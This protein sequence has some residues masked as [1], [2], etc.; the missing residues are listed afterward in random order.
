M[1][2]E[3]KS[4][5]FK[6]ASKILF[7][8]KQTKNYLSL[9]NK[10]FSSNQLLQNQFWFLPI[11]FKKLVRLALKCL[12][13]G[14]FTV[15]E[16]ED[17]TYSIWKELTRF[18]TLSDIIFTVMLVTIPPYIY[19]EIISTMSFRS[20]F[21]SKPVHCQYSWWCL[22]GRTLI[23]HSLHVSDTNYFKIFPVNINNPD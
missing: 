18:L 16:K 2:H 8:K 6:T 3:V 10:R 20:V 5:F 19:W 14:T 13:S 22:K 4:A 21:I 9:S 15:S 12:Q 1:D 7:L 17:T 11:F 23:E